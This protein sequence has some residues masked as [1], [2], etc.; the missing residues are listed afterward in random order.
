MSEEAM[1]VPQEAIDAFVE[2]KPSFAIWPVRSSVHANGIAKSSFYAGFAA[3]ME[4]DKAEIVRTVLP[5]I[6]RYE[7]LVGKAY[8]GTLE[9]PSQ[10]AK[11][12]ADLALALTARQALGDTPC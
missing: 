12:E 1:K 5:L 4:A 10:A 8:R 3:A 11:Y 2:W 9:I 7:A 6:E